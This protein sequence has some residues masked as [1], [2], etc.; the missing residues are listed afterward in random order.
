MRS[1]DPLTPLVSRKGHYGSDES[2]EAH[3][4]VFEEM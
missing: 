3:S 2:D 4:S 1:T